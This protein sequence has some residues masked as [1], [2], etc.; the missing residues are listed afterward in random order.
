MV[1]CNLDTMEQFLVSYGLN[2]KLHVAQRVANCPL[3]RAHDNFVEVRENYDT[4]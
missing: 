4:T 3:P 2:D 1:V